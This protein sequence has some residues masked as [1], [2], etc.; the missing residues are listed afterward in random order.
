MINF[1]LLAWVYGIAVSLVHICLY[2][3]KWNKTVDEYQINQFVASHLL[4]LFVGFWPIFMLGRMA[5]FLWLKL[6]RKSKASASK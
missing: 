6:S 1:L 3:E 4:V 2:P 5:Q